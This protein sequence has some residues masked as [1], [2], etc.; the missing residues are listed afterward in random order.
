MKPWLLQRF[1]R[2]AI[3]SGLDDQL[4]GEVERALRERMRLGLFLGSLIEAA[5]RVVALRPDAVDWSAH[6]DFAEA[7][8]RLEERANA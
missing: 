4:R 2:A 7:L 8:R 5:Q 3:E 6:P 1:H